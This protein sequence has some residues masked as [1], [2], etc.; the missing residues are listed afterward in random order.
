MQIMDGIKSMIIQPIVTL[1]F[2]LGFL[3]FLWGLVEFMA[4]PADSSKKKT[5]LDH[6]KYGILGLMIMV[7][8][9]GITGMVTDVLGIKCKGLGEGQPCTYGGQ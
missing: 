2:S 1:L 3:I 5:G 6:M 4:N 7:S 8:I 9:W